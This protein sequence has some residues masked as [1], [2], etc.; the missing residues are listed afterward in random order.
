MHIS[1]A[2]VERF[3]MMLR[4]ENVDTDPSMTFFSLNSLQRINV[5]HRFDSLNL[6]L[7]SAQFLILNDLFWKYLPR[8]GTHRSKVFFCISRCDT[9]FSPL[10]LLAHSCIGFFLIISVTGDLKHI[11]FVP[12]SIALS[13]NKL[14]NI[15]LFSFDAS[16]LLPKP[17]EFSLLFGNLFSLLVS[18]C[19]PCIGIFIPDI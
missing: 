13:F 7:N 4:F 14:N 5:V 6:G 15:F 16:L 2:K 17:I 1:N 9:F 8:V 19:D 11:P 12:F 10:Y 3:E 18:V